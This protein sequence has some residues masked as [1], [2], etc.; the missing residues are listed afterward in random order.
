[1]NRTHPHFLLALLVASLVFVRPS[2]LHAQPYRHAA[3]IRAGVSSGISYKGF[4][5][6][7]MSAFQLD[8]LYNNHGLNLDAL[9]EYHLEPFIRNKRTLLYLGGGLSGGEWD[10][11]FA[12]G[13]VAVA[14]MEYTLRDLPL[15]FSVDWKPILNLIVDIE[16]LWFDFGLSIRYRFKK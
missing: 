1:M 14:G 15:N 3:G 13:L 8:F 11:D 16:P 6:H 10:E 12:L 4:L 2:E 7:R 9:Y 5:L